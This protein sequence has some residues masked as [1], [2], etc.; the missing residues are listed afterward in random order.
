MQLTKNFILSEFNCRDGTA[1]P[2]HLIEIIKELAANLQVL[3]DFIKEPIHISSAYRTVKHNIAVDGE[4]NSY[5]LKA[6]AAD[7]TAKSY[8]PRRLAA[9]IKK[10][11]S[12]G[13]MK[14]G[15]IGVYAG[16]VHYDIRG[17]AARW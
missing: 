5:H 1:V 9:I 4:A 6:M 11:I 16:F 17:Y 2:D 13:R 7:I 10:L 3:R 8:S 12:Q 15:G 14:Q